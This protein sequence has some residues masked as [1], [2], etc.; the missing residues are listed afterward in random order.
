M[1]PVGFIKAKHWF[2]SY[3]EGVSAG[4][5]IFFSILWTKPPSSSMYCDTAV[6]THSWE[7]DKSTLVHGK[8][9]KKAKH[10]FNSG[11]Q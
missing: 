2:T 9:K 4:K 5:T 7:I 11:L 1:Q 6:M 8:R 10:L 3:P